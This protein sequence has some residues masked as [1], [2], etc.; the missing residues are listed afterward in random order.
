MSAGAGLVLVADDSA[1][2]RA[3]GRLELEAAGF[4]V[5]EAAVR[6]GLRDAVLLDVEMPVLDG[7]A[8]LEALKADPATAAVPVVFLTGRDGT[9]EIGRALRA[10]AHDHVSKPPEPTELLARLV[11]ADRRLYAAKDS[12]RDQ[13]SLTG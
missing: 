5:L 10:G 2:V 13:I 9:V 8:V 11:L 7:Y 3:I 4:A 12:G 6:D 1:T